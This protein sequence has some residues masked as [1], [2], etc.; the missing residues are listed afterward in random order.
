[1][2]SIYK[3]CVNCDQKKRHINTFDTKWQCTSCEQPSENGEIYCPHCNVKTEHIEVDNFTYDCKVC[4]KR[5]ENVRG[6]SVCEERL[7]HKLTWSEGEGEV[8][9]NCGNDR[10]HQ[11]EE[12][13][14][15]DEDGI[16]RVD[17]VRVRQDSIQPKMDQKIYISMGGF[18][19]TRTIKIHKK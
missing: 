19:I 2:A 10:E 1:M 4:H 12:V 9:I 16:V 8:C 6:C 15:A 7:A 11:I 17:I 3:F 13:T 5:Q 14:E 18:S